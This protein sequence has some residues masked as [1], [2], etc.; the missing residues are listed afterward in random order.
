M[1]NHPLY[2]IDTIFLPWYQDLRTY[3]LAEYPSS[4]EPIPDDVPLPP[5]YILRLASS[6]EQQL[7]PP[8]QQPPPV[9]RME[10]DPDAAR[11]EA[12][13]TTVA[14]LTHVDH[15]DNPRSH[16]EQWDIQRLERRDIVDATHDA[17]SD[18]AWEA[19]HGVPVDRLDKAN[20]IT[21]H[22]EKYLM[23]RADDDEKKIPPPDNLSP[24][25]G[26][27]YAEVVENDRITPED[28][29]QDVRKLVLNLPFLEGEDNL[30]PQIPT[31][32][33]VIL[34][35]KNYPEDVQTIIDLME[36]Q[37]ICDLPLE[38]DRSR[39]PAEP[40][41]ARIRRFKPAKLFAD[42]DSTLRDLLTNN[43]DFTAIPKR[44]F[45][46]EVAEFAADPRER[47][48]LIEFVIRG[49]E[50]EF[51]DY[52]TRPR[53]TILEVLQD[54]PSVRIPF[55]Q[56]VDLFPLIRGREFSIAN[57]G[58]ELKGLEFKDTAIHLVAAL[59]EYKTIIRKPRQGLCSRYIKT[60]APGTS[61]MIGFKVPSSEHDVLNPNWETISRPVIA[62]ATG[63][64]IAPIRAVLQDRDVY[65]DEADA[66]VE[67]GPV[68]LFFGCRN[69]HADFH[70]QH[71]WAAAPDMTVIPAF[72]RDPVTPQE[73]ERHLNPYKY[74]VADRLP[75]ERGGSGLTSKGLWTSG[76][77]VYDYDRGKNYVQHKIRRHARAVCELMAQR[78]FVL[79]CGNSGRMPLSVRDAIKDALVLGG[80]VRDEDAA[81]RWLADK[82]NLT[83]WEETW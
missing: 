30:L 73:Q 54:F 12:T 51:Y 7:Q 29:W 52:T 55:G 32:S 27:F 23:K 71:E 41:V 1:T 78:P 56:T 77:T 59:V 11:F 81:R 9:S 46:R 74:N 21:D 50:Q 79:L 15:V 48:R 70:F 45:L 25:P 65:R 10:G 53:R 57:G 75:V 64:G 76:L 67:V 4:E 66:P 28:H 24:I 17:R 43:F 63:T 18:E 13:K 47:E 72:S 37:D 14:A 42:P 34:Y 36:W 83:W 31:G 22:P 44:N 26:T 6:S 20:I 35:P 60:L 38:W 33:T 8:Q 19:L 5:K 58:K 16:Q 82:N 49:N 69:E 61:L 3:L 40:G 80:L 39:E 68:L 2:S 62:I